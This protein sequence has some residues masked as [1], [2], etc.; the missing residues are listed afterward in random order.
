VDAEINVAARARLADQRDA[1]RAGRPDLAVGVDRPE[2][3]REYRDNVDAHRGP[4]RE[5][6]R[7]HEG[8]MHLYDENPSPGK[9]SS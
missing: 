1:E 2:V 8:F 7:D 6:E 9:K 3:I 5:A 4:S